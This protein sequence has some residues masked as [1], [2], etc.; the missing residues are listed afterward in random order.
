[1]ALVHVLFFLVTANLLRLAIE[2]HAAGNRT[3]DDSSPD[4]TFTGNWLV[5]SCSKCNPQPDSGQA[6]NGTWRTNND[7]VATMQLNFTGSAIW[8]FGILA[9]ASTQGSFTITLDGQSPMVYNVSENSNSSYVYNQLLFSATSLPTSTHRLLLESGSDSAS[10]HSI[11]LDYAVVNSDLPST[12][13]TSGA[14]TISGSGASQS[15]DNTSIST[16]SGHSRVGETVGIVV[17]ALVALAIAAVLVRRYR[18][19]HDETCSSSESQLSIPC[20]EETRVVFPVGVQV[21]RPEA[22]YNSDPPPRYRP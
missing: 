20:Y 4:F 18:R 9:P 13:I 8:L 22:M 15:G 6:H 19:P 2:V 3:I 16:S 7:D 1:M 10:G 5:N 17:G 12:T 11:I 21:C 14:P